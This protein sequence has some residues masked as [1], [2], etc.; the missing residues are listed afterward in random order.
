MCREG[1]DFGEDNSC[2]SLLFLKVWSRWSCSLLLSAAKLQDGL[3]TVNYYHNFF[4]L[5]KIRKGDREWKKTNENGNTRIRAAALS[6]SISQID[7]KA[8]RLILQR[9]LV[10]NPV[11][12]PFS[13]FHAALLL[14]LWWL[15]EVMEK[16]W[17]FLQTHTTATVCDYFWHTFC[18]ISTQSGS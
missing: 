9:L 17:H 12:N 1:V 7:F 6:K 3:F 18:M 16:S 10:N 13:L 15:W 14:A 4:L 2:Y 8:T 5:L 11:N